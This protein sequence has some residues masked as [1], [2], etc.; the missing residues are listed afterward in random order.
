MTIIMASGS[1]YIENG[2]GEF[3]VGRER[4]EPELR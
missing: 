2:P 3:V 4:F 1:R